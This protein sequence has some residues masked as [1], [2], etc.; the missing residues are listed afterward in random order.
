MYKFKNN[1][2]PT[3]ISTL[4]EQ[5]TVK[6]KL[7]NHD[8]TTPSLLWKALAQACRPEVW[9]SVPSNG[10]EASTLVFEI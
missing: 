5:P 3:Y 7:R 6:Y 9:S 8:L 2:S 10:K 1:M 4:F